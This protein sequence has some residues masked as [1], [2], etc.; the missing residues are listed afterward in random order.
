MRI[1]EVNE[2]SIEQAGRIHSESWQDSHKAFCSMEFVERHTPAAQTEYLRR[3]AAAGKHIFLLIDQYPVGIVTVHKNLIENLYVLPKEQRKGY[4]SRLLEYAI[5]VCS[6][7]PALWVLNNNEGAR[8]LYKKHGFQESGNKK[9]LTAVL[10]ELEM[11]RIKQGD[12]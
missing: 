12:T 10:W 8:R 6:G 5:Q 9:L 7:E 1:V 11:K 4:G 3:E 2:K